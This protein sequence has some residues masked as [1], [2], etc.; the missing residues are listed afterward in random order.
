MFNA[1][2]D[3]IRHATHLPDPV[4]HVM[5]GL[6]VFVLVALVL[7]RGFA[8]WWPFLV[9][10]GLQA[11]NEINDAVGD[12]LRFGDVDVR[13]TVADTVLT[14]VIPALIVL[15]ARARRRHVRAAG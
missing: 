7:R 10:A 8:S 1:I 5:I 6:V 14:L 15:V 12:V 11:I 3:V 9:V 4:L 2:K 13:G